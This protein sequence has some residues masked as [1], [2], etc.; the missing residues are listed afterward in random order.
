MYL[1]TSGSLEMLL[2]FYDASES[3]DNDEVNDWFDSDNSHVR[4]GVG[5][6]AETCQIERARLLI[7]ILQYYIDSLS[8]TQS[9]P[10]SLPS[11][12]DRLKRK[13]IEV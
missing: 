2:L 3:Q 11:A 1:T 12:N 9:A 7:Y 8:T 5:M 6:I 4:S 10:V 13:I